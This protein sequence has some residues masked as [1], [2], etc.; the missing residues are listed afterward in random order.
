MAKKSTA[1]RQNNAARRSQTSA[2]ATGATLVRQPQE[3]VSASAGAST[4]VKSLAEPRATSAA[5]V[6]KPRA[7]VSATPVR[8]RA[9]EAPKVAAPKAAAPKPE[10]APS[11]PRAGNAQAAR[12]ARARATQ[13]ARAANMITPEHYSYVLTDLKLI[14][15]LAVAMFVIIIVLHFVLG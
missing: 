1:A 9:L 10:P 2:K 4:A 14:A 11:K 7:A 5:P 15:S 6:E 12:L 8:P 3:P 13:R